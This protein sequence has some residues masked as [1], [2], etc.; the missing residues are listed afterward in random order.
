MLAGAVVQE[1][2]LEKP[3][4]RPLPSNKMPLCADTDE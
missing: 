3:A 1:L 2:L 4:P